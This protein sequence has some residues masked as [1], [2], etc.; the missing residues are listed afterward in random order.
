LLVTQ[1][2]R[3]CQWRATH[4]ER[5]IRRLS[6]SFWLAG[7]L[8]RTQQGT[9]DER[10]VHDT[11]CSLTFASSKDSETVIVVPLVVVGTVCIKQI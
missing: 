2:E 1:R 4:E 3:V 7:P 8:Q 11:H 5:E 9:G 6:L 10:S